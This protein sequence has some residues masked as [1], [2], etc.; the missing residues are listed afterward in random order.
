[1]SKLYVYRGWKA[2][3]N[4]HE[5]NIPVLPERAAQILESL[6]T[7]T[8]ML[9][10]C[11]KWP[12]MILDNGLTPG[13]SGGH[14]KIR[15]SVSE[16]VPGK[17]VEFRF[18]PMPSLP[19]FHGHHYFEVVQRDADTVFRHTIDVST[20]FRTWVYWKIFIE[21]VHDAVI[22]DAFDKVERVAGVPRPHHSRWSLHV[23]FLRWLR[24]R[25]AKRTAQTSVA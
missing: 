18:A 11:E 19:E 13:S 17:R 25:Q 23:R 2:I 12:P 3:L 6:A 22:E 5:R 9:W 20:D 21:H 4:L 24:T 1:M 10:P 16:H 15:Y 7:S 8:D 14:S